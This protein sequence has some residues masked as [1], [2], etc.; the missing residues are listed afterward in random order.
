MFAQRHRNPRRVPPVDSQPMSKVASTP[1]GAALD[2]FPGY[3]TCQPPPAARWSALPRPTAGQVCI[4][5][6]IGVSTRAVRDGLAPSASC[7]GPP[8]RSLVRACSSMS[9]SGS[10]SAI[11]FACAGRWHHGCSSPV[12]IL[13]IL[14]ASFGALVL[15]SI[16]AFLLLVSVL[17]IATVVSILTGLLLMF[18]L[19][20]HAGAR[21]TLPP[22]SAGK[23]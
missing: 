6:K 2:D 23:A 10:P 22:A 17:S 13:R 15:A 4:A 16:G 5:A 7:E 19:G 21:T 1:T 14:V 8:M 11:L 9:P 18:G 3:P 12:V 20:V